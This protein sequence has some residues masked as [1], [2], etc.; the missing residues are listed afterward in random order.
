MQTLEAGAPIAA[1]RQHRDSTL[2]AASCDDHAIRILDTVVGRVVRVLRGHT[3]TI[4][5]FDWSADGRWILSCSLD[6][7]IRIVDVPSGVAIGW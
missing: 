2:L 6:A 7:T 1:L 5:D 3:N 4:S